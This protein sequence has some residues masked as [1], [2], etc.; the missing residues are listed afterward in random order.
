MD[1]RKRLGGPLR[2]AAAA[3][4]AAGLSA[5][6]ARAQ[7]A[8]MIVFAAASLKNALDAVNLQWRKET[9]KKAA[10][11]YAASSALAKQ[12]EQGAPAQMFV[13]ADVDWMD[14]LA[15]KN[16]IRADTRSNLLGN[17]I[18]LIAAKER[19]AKVEAGL[20]VDLRRPLLGSDQHDA[21]AQQIGARVGPYQVL[22]R[23]IVHPVDVG[24][25]EH[26][27]RRAL[28]DLFRQRRACRVGDGGLLAGLLAPLQVDGIERVLEARGSE[29]DH[30]SLLSAGRRCGQTRGQQRCGCQAQRPAKPFASIHSDPPCRSTNRATRI[31]IHTPWL[32]SSGY[33]AALGRG[34]KGSLTG[35]L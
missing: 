18:V 15:R 1:G 6:P 9:G 34:R 21:V 26:L 25:D 32:C 23:E 22:P 10:I 30:V 4:L 27:R 11:S 19:A 7:Q 28:L 31:E 13:S 3:L 5:A 2:L 24:G 20:D 17:R 14:Y 29:D 12:I 16:L 35:V 8:D 33:C